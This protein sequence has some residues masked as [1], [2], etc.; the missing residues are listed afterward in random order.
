MMM[1]AAVKLFI[2]WRSFSFKDTAKYMKIKK[3]MT[4][5][6]GEDITRDPK[7]LQ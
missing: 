5:P 1:G 3:F 6:P 4:P 2:V 7:A